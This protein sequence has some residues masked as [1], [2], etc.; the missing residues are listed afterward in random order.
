M[1]T[2]Y[3]TT[4]SATSQRHFS[5]SLGEG[6][7]ERVSLAKNVRGAYS[8]RTSYNPQ[9]SVCAQQV[10]QLEKLERTNVRKPQRI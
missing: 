2:I 3:N 9:I 1:V 5:A 10:R 7:R 4:L 6:F 8:L